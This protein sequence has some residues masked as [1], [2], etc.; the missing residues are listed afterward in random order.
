MYLHYADMI[1]NGYHRT[2]PCPFQS[3][4]LLLNPER[5][6]VLLRE[7]AEARQRARRPPPSRSTSRPR[8]W[9]TAQQLKDK[10]C[11][12]CLSP[13]QVNVGAMKQFVP[14]AK[15]SVLRIFF[16]SSFVGNFLPSIGGD[17]YRAYQLAQ[18]GVR[19]GEAA[20]SVLMDRIV[21]V[22]SMVLVAAVALLFLREFDLPGVV[23]AFLL[24]TAACA[25][26]AGAVFSSRD[27]CR[28]HGQPRR[29]MPDGEAHSARRADGRDP[30]LRPTP[31][32]TRLGPCALRRRPAASGR[33]GILS[34]AGRLTSRC[35]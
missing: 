20:A 10:V 15:L 8:T 29:A 23:P 9:R 26:A 12:T 19:S 24:V 16:V 2:M 33:A 21:G 5:R 6:S 13:C 18:L 34:S 32:G 25:V 11:P 35:R 17:V 1:A 22:L 31:R 28:R 30:P 3:Q 14:Y 7:L 4:G 27:R